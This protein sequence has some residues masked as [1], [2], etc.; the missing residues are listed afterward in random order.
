M[1]KR[2][3]KLK[4]REY[5]MQGMVWLGTVFFFYCSLTNYHKRSG[6]NN[7]HLLSSNSVGQKSNTDL[8]GLK[9]KFRWDHIL[10]GSL[11]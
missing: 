11:S 2:E 10:F 7:T 4:I 5:N 1:D 3:K 8:S 6:L 9:S